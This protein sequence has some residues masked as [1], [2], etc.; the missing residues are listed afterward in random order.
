MSE[1]VEIEGSDRELVL[2]AA[3]KAS[4]WDGGEVPTN[5]PL[6]LAVACYVAFEET[7]SESDVA[8][9]LTDVD[10][11]DATTN[12]T[13]LAAA[14]VRASMLELWWTD[15][16]SPIGNPLRAFERAR[17]V[18]A[19]KPDWVLGWL[20]LGDSALHVGDSAALEEARQA[21]AGLPFEPT[22][23]DPVQIA[24]ATLFTGKARWD[25]EQKDAYLASFSTPKG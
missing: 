15:A 16:M 20:V 17:L 22:P 14:H 2:W 12:P 8:R 4:S 7:W 11:L 24:F 9:L 21:L 19:L 5:T 3:G 23:S 25:A 10:D 6:Q 18:V 13:W 1:I